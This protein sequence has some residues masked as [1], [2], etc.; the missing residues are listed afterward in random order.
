MKWA[1]MCGY[2]VVTTMSD[3]AA[4]LDTCALCPDNEDGECRRCRCFIEA[5]V[6]VNTEACPR[7]YWDR[8]WVKRALPKEP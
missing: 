6:S 7:G 1:H 4:R 5:K 8:I 3:R 2:A